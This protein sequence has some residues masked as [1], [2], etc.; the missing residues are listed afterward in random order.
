MFMSLASFLQDDVAPA[1]EQPSV[2]IV[3]LIIMGIVGLLMIASMWKVFAK[4]GEPGW[5]ILVPI[6]NLLTLLKVAG[7]P[8][9]WFILFLIPG[10]NTIIGILVAIEL[11][12]KFGQG[13]GFGLGL[14]FLPMI[15]Y[16]MLAFGSSTYQR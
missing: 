1:F 2:P 5:A 6:Y 10:L 7:K 16:P 3:P 15:F 12:K 14:V 9:W 8:G 11:A 13:T 4:A